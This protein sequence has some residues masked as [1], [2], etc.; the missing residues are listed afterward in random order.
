M[1]GKKLRVLQKSYYDYL[2]RKARNLAKIHSTKL[3]LV[4]I[5][6]LYTCTNI[7]SDFRNDNF[8]TA[9]HHPVTSDLEFLI[10]RTVYHYLKRSK[11]KSDWKVYLRRQVDGVA[12]DVRISKNDKTMAIIEI[13]AKVGWIQPVFSKRAVERDPKNAKVTIKSFK[14]Q[15]EKYQEKFKIK[16]NQIFVLIPSLKEAHR[17]EGILSEYVSNF[18]NN[19]GLDKNNL[20][21]LS[22]NLKLDLDKKGIPNTS[23]KPTKHFEDFIKSLK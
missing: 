19:S 18:V 2:D 10:A 15:L 23:Y 5:H 22:E 7:E 6:E 3:L 1:A 17:A 4:Y 20:M 21:L 9:Y 12:P 13:K 16:K 8:E 11:S 14:E